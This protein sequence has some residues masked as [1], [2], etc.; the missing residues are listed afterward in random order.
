MKVVIGQSV[1]SLPAKS[2]KV[3]TPENSEGLVLRRGFPRYCQNRHTAAIHAKQ[4]VVK[5][6]PARAD[7]QDST[8]LIASVES[9]K[10]D[11]QTLPRWKPFQSA[12][13]DEV[14]IGRLERRC[15]EL[16][17]YLPIKIRLH[18]GR[19]QEFS[20]WCDSHPEEG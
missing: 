16:D 19:V 5:I 7:G 14:S 20:A 11:P 13:I 18:N 4:I 8:V 12:Q 3:V 15:R 17:A 9:R 6:S 1:Y 2:I 10:P